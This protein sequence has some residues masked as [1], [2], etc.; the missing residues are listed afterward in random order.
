MRRNNVSGSTDERQRVNEE[1]NVKKEEEKLYTVFMFCAAVISNFRN[2]QHNV[3]DTQTHSLT[4][5][6]LLVLSRIL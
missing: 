4:H 1:R 2:H 5:P 6:N 3:V